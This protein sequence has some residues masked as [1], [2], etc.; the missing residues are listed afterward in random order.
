MVRQ[1]AS[2]TVVTRESGTAKLSMLNL[3]VALRT[4][5]VAKGSTLVH[6][7]GSESGWC[8]SARAPPS[9]TLLPPACGAYAKDDTPSA[10]CLRVRF[11]TI[12]SAMRRNDLVG[13]TNHDSPTC[14]SHHDRRRQR[15][16]PTVTARML[17]CATS[18][19][20]RYRS[21]LQQRRF[22]PGLKLSVR[23]RARRRWPA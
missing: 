4:V 19:P 6:R 16:P 22:G 20:V 23:R 2:T 9:S 3:N 10:F 8:T 15:A 11:V 5:T 17:C 21:N 18:A 1:W 7:H 13:A 12:G 14:I